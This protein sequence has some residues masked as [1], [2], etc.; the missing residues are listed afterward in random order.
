MRFV[1]PQFL[2]AFLLLAIPILIHLYNFRK[3]KSLY[4]SSLQ[5]VKKIELETK[6]TKKLKQ[7]LILMSRLL[8]LI[9]A[10]LAF[11]QPYI[12]VTKNA[13]GGNPVLA[14]YVDNSFSMGQKGTEGELISEAREVAKRL[15]NESSNDTRYVLVTNEMSGK[16]QRVVS[17]VEALDRIDKIQLSPLVRNIGDVINWE[18]DFLRNYNNEK[19][20]ISSVQLVLL[21]DFQKSTF[22][23]Q[24]IAGDSTSF[25]YPIQFVPQNNA[26][27]SVD[28]VWF[29][30]PTVKVGVS[31]VLNVLVK[32]HGKNDIVNGELHFELGNLKRDV[33]LDIPAN[34][35]L[36]TSFTFVQPNSDVDRPQLGKLSIQDKQVFFDDDFYFSF[37]PKRNCSV[38][39]VNGP[40]AVEN[41]GTVFELDEY[42]SI[43]IIDQGGFTL[44]NLK[45]AD[46]VVLNGM[47]E[48]STGFINELADFKKAQGTVLIFPGKELVISEFNLL[49]KELDLGRILGK[50]SDGTKIKT[51]SYNDLFFRPVF[52]KKPTQLNLPAISTLYQSTGSNSISLITAQNGQSVFSTSLDRRS[53]LFHSSLDP[54]FSSFTSNALFSTLVLRTGELSN[55]PTPLFITIGS[56]DRFPLFNKTKSEKPLHLVL[57]KIDFIPQ[58]ERI[59]NI[60]YITL[61]GTEATEKLQAGNYA[62]QSD[63]K[64][65]TLSLNYN[66]QESDLTSMTLSEIEKEWT[67]AGIKNISASSIREGQSL[68]KLDLTKPFEYWRWMLLISLLF[69]FS[70]MALIRFM[71]K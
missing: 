70:E 13:E 55:K 39:I 4:F 45:T 9:F 30:E 56:P 20:R 15:I 32:N 43:S 33:F 1:Y 17:K 38:L 59:G 5:F 37:Q 3:Y 6:S 27:C 21:S 42:Y 29:S 18:R 31:N 19:E 11:A 50:T 46:L 51:V 71:K 22:Q 60:E 16:E 57:D 62:I 34:Q 28:S 7:I 40:D 63:D 48:Y 24:N 64:P 26:N 61:K 68:A 12:P 65:A 54:S 23:S 10:I 67:D 47:N 25:Y 14:I 2:W 66:R 36:K 53:F 8:F 58:I 49:T 52:E 69:L 44:D 35:S 41:V